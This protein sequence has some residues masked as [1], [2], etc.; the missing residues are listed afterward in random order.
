[1]SVLLRRREDL[2]TTPE[3]LH[4]IRLAGLVKPSGDLVGIPA[5]SQHREYRSLA[6]APSPVPQS[7]A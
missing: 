1:M 3:R 7:I 4:A 2:M 6:G 5:R